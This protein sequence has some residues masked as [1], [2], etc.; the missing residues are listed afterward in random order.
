MAT[1]VLAF[2]DP[3]VDLA[4]G[5]GKAVN[6]GRLTRSGFP[7]PDGFVVATAAYRSA[8]AATPGL[9]T[10]IEAALADGDPTDPVTAES[11]AE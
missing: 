6:L 9:A 2:D 5:G 7:V 11:A 8:V 4:V 10:L 1:W 3:G